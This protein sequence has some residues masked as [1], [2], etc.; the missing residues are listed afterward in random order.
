MHMDP[1]THDAYKEAYL[2]YEGFKEVYQQLQSQIHVHDCDNKVDYHLQD[3]LLY[4]L[5]KLCILKGECLQLIRE[6]H[7]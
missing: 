5:D 4:M 3:G 6:A 1:F 7:T 2:K